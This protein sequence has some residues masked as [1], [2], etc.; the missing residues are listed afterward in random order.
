[1]SGFKTATRVQGEKVWQELI[2]ISAK[3]MNEHIVQS[4]E[5]FLVSRAGSRFE[6]ASSGGGLSSLTGHVWVVLGPHILHVD[7]GTSW[8][9]D[10]SETSTLSIYLKKGGR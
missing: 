7:P 1:M 3:S 6:R 5:K 10:N 2:H 4:I 9:E 8:M